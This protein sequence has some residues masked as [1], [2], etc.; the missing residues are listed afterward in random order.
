MK[1]RIK[2]EGESIG[3]TYEYAGSNK[4]KCSHVTKHNSGVEMVMTWTLD[5]S[6]VT[7]EELCVEAAKN[8]VIDL[9]GPWKKLPLAEAEEYGEH[10]YDIREWFD[11]E[12]RRVAKTDS[13][14]AKAAMSKLSPEELAELMKMFT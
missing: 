4:V 2:K 11:R 5:Y 8:T 3:R 14:K 7:H 9:R 13:E 6:D 10:E 1:A 12:K